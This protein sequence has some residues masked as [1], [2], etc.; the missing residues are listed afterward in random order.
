[1]G[2]SCFTLIFGFCRLLSTWFWSV[3]KINNQ[4]NI[5]CFVKQSILTSPLMLAVLLSSANTSVNKDTG[6]PT[7]SRI[8]QVSDIIPYSILHVV[9]SHCLTLGYVNSGTLLHRALICGVIYISA[10]RIWYS[11]SFV[12]RRQLESRLSSAAHRLSFAVYQPDLA[13]HFF[14]WPSTSISTKLRT[15]YWVCLHPS[16]AGHV[17]AGLF[18]TLLQ[19]ARGS[20][21]LVNSSALSYSIHSSLSIFLLRRRSLENTVI[22][23]KYQDQCPSQYQA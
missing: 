21:F 8:R 22:P 7:A 19:M 11:Y 10:R 4:Q 16:V 2:S 15:E 12:L 20:L 18:S 13:I 3:P 5:Q 6:Q 1:M 14:I 23:A 9:S 17:P